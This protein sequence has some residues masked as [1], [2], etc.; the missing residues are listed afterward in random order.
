MKVE[1]MPAVRPQ[2]SLSKKGAVGDRF[3]ALLADM[4]ETEIASAGPP[5]S[6]SDLSFILGLQDVD[7]NDARK[8]NR[9]T[10]LQGRDILDSLTSLQ[11][12]LLSPG[13]PIMVELEALLAETSSVV[14]ADPDLIKMVEQLRIRAAVEIAKQRIVLASGVSATAC[15]T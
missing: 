12:A 4:Q 7:Y 9:K 3:A 10:L 8:R 11:H 5:A 1:G 13:A 2:G 15:L 6:M 14:A